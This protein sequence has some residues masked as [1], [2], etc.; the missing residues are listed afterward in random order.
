[1]K[2]ERRRKKRSR[3]M[4]ARDGRTNRD[5]RIR[6]ERVSGKEKIM[7]TVIG[8]RDIKKGK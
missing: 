3:R 8:E 5:R 1:M 4:G 2:C 7:E 6:R